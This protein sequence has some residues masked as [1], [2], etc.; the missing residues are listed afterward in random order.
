MSNPERWRAGQEGQALLVVLVAISLLS[1]IGTAMTALWARSVVLA[2]RQADET[3]ALY[4]AEAGIVRGIQELTASGGASLSLG[5]EPVGQGP[6]SATYMVSTRP[7]G[8]GS[9]EVTS[10]GTKGKVSRSVRVLVAT[11]FFYPSYAGGLLDIDAEAWW[12]GNT[13]IEFSPAPAYGSAVSVR[14]RVL[15]EK[16]VYRPLNLPSI[17]FASFAGAAGPVPSSPPSLPKSG[18]SLTNGWYRSKECDSVV[19]VPSGVKAGILGDLTCRVEVHDGAILVVTGNLRANRVEV[20]NGGQLVVG[21][22]VDVGTLDLLGNLPARGGGL[23]VAGGSVKI[24]TASLL[25]DS[26]GEN[27]LVILALD[28]SNCT[29]AAC[30]ADDSND[31]QITDLG[32]VN[33]KGS[34]MNLVAYAG[35][36]PGRTPQVTLNFGNLFALGSTDL[37]KGSVVSAGNLKLTTSTTFGSSKVRIEADP[38]AVARF[39]SQVPGAGLWTQLSWDM[40]GP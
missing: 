23:M 15:P 32:L 30:G 33:V 4:A 16:P 2:Q 38:A 5:P 37:I 25:S 7:L 8:D 22:D 11:P 28:R 27:A 26:V 39:T 36:L 9:Y 21:G 40:T 18:G 14:G 3:A 31:I 19:K 17:P 6:F 10:T 20:R 1:L 34:R 24:G 13:T 12:F 35:P 29:A